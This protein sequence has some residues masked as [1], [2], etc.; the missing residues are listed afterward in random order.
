LAAILAADVAGYSRL[1]HDDEETTHAKLTALLL[2]GVAPAIS[3]HGGRIVKNTGDGFLAEF[4][5]AVEAV[6]AAVQFQTHIKE[7]TI[8]EVE[9]RRIA[10]RVGVNIGD[11]IVEPHDIFGDGVNIAARL[12]SIADPGGICISSAAYDQV[13]GKVGV[14]FADLGDQN[15][16]NIARPVR[17]YAVVWD[18][19]GPTTKSGSTTPRPPSAPRL[20]I[21]VLPFANIG[22]DPEQDYFVDGVT[23]N[24]TTDLSR[25]GGLFVLARNSAF[26]YKGKAIDVRQVG[27]ELNVRYVL[28]GSVQRSG[29][30][31]R[32]NVQLIDAESGIHLWADRF[33]KPVAELFDMQDEI[34][35]RLANT[36]S[37]QLTAVEAWR[38]KSSLHPDAMDLVFQGFA[39]LANPEHLTQARGFFER[40]LAIDPRSVRALVG[41]ANIDMTMGVDLLTDERAA[42]LSAAETNAIKALSLAPDYALAHLI[43]AL[44]CIVTNRAGQGIAECEQALALNR[45]LAYAHGAIGLAKLYMGRPAETEGHVLEAFR[46][47]PRD[48]SAYRLMRVVG[49][50][51]LQLGAD[52]EAVGWLRRSIAAKR[53]HPLAHFAL[54]AALGLLGALDEAQTAAKAGLAL[55]AGFTI[56]RLRAAKISDNP[57]YLAGQERVCEGMRIAGVPEG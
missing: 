4:P 13:R 32:V 26:S 19:V 10:F 18:G 37:V 8:S 54:A 52:S 34:V 20:S 42:L 5:S 2:D 17:A 41:M 38:A 23:E 14:E 21:V 45:N 29:K 3:E 49:V 35:S 11:V 39:S 28:E 9:D 15:L 7:L 30:R 56:R 47:S 48:I 27:R 22:G 51:K 16:K 12:E 24:L 53:N 31:L 57:I 6:R 40:A 44:V 1:M 33:E 43:L 36:L 55:N 50:A 25:I 46:L